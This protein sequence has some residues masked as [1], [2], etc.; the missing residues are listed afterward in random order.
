M[1]PVQSRKSVPAS[2][3]QA[4]GLPTMPAVAVEVLRLCREEKT[5]LDELA[6]ILSFDAA[7]SAR[8]LS[9]ANSSLYNL[10]GAVSSLQRAALVLGMK[11]VQ[12]MALSFS[13]ASSL[14]RSNDKNRF[15]YE[16]FWRRSVVRAVASR[17]LASRAKTLTEDEAFLC[18]LLAELGQVALA[19]CMG[20]EYDE[21]LTRAQ[22]RWPSC[23]LE[24]EVLG[25]DHADVSGAIFE[26]WQ[27]PAPVSFVLQ[28]LYHPDELPRDAKPW[29]F[30]LVDVLVVASHITDLL[31]EEDPTRALELAE[32]RSRESF[33]YEVGTLQAFIMSLETRVREASEM[34]S[35]R[36][37]PGKSYEE[38]VNEARGVFL[39]L[40]LSN[41]HALHEARLEHRERMHDDPVFRDAKTGVPNRQAFDSFLDAEIA[42]R[43]GGT[44]DRP[45][46]VLL[47]EVDRLASGESKLDDG[48]REE[49]LRLIGSTL[50]RLV[51]RIDLVARL[52]EARFAVVLSET[53]PFGIRALSERLR[54]GVEAQSLTTPEGRLA[55]TITLG[56][57]CLA[58]VAS[59]S[60]GAALV[61][62]ARRCLEKA[63]SQ[64]HN[65]AVV[66]GTVLRAGRS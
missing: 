61:E 33:G 16:R 27:L 55:A 47:I 51:R 19:Q 9:F 59:R 4:D 60:D 26:C 5:S 15:D 40:S 45:L 13:L 23:Q 36:L 18:G 34:L 11:T 17:A 2:L 21:V 12:L 65:R 31:T 44:L 35:V 42:A 62:V 52:D 25:F 58:S 3:I 7:L 22:G 56:G 1:S 30:R 49:I 29:M 54:G 8:L 39:K 53:S 20:A 10:G 64:G 38:I 28:G 24:R 6:H 46:G 43:L 41:A 32:R 14:P 66:H 37:P 57:A 50:L 48:A 63:K